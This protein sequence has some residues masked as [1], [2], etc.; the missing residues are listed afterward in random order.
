[1]A[2]AKP[3][4]SPSCSNDEALVVTKEGLKALQDE[5]ELL[6]TTRRRQVAERLKEAI[7]YGDLSENSEYEEA[8]NEQAFMEGRILELEEMIKSAKVVDTTSHSKQVVEIGTK[9]KIKDLK[10][11]TEFD[12]ILVGS[13]EADPFNG[14]ISNEAPLGM[15]LIG[16]KVGDVVTVSMKDGKTDYEVLKLA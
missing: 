9:V 3:P 2:T 4:K 14:R 15:A 6:S 13:T 5:L 12:L 10:K 8:K 16:A 7:S 11:K 1:M